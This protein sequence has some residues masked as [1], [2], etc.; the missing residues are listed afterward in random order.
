MQL[1]LASGSPRRL[2]LLQQIYPHFEVIPSQIDEVL[3]AEISDIALCVAD[4]AAQKAAAVCLTQNADCC[5]LGADTIVY[6][7]PDILGK[8]KDEADAQRMLRALSGQK[9][10]V[11]TGVALY[12]RQGKRIQSSMSAATSVVKMREITDAEISLYI[13]SGEPMDKA[14]SYAI[15]GGA[16]AFIETIEGSY[17]NIVGLPLELTQSLFKDLGVHQK[18]V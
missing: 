7:R 14:G 12:M 5:V 6:L 10:Q 13:A 9:H 15:Q 3:N 16:K 4:L 8:P 2:D 17:E 18:F 11:I 1:I